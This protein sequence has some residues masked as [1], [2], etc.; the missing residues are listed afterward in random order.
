MLLAGGAFEVGTSSSGDAVGELTSQAGGFRDAR[1]L[2]R[3]ETGVPAM[4]SRTF[5]PFRTSTSVNRAVAAGI[6]RPSDSA[7]TIC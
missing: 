7:T 4:P 2:Y 6:W 1:T 5:F 3:S